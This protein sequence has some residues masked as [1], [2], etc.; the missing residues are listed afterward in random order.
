MGLRVAVAET[1]PREHPIPTGPLLLRDEWLLLSPAGKVPSGGEGEPGW[2]R[3][4]QDDPSYLHLMVVPAYRG[5][6]VELGSPL[7]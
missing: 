6:C 7:G 5:S 3:P 1:E 2:R 4:P